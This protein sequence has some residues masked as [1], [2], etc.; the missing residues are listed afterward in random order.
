[1][2]T[3]EGLKVLISDVVKFFSFC[4][5]LSVSLLNIEHALQ[6]LGCDTKTG[7]LSTIFKTADPFSIEPHIFAAVLEM[8]AT[9]I[10]WNKSNHFKT[11]KWNA[12][13]ESRPIGVWSLIVF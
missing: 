10:Q 1:M 13:M 12:R 8:H 2:L 9:V 5:F 7:L 3:L 6:I 11:T 4:E